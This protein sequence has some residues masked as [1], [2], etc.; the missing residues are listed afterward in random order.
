MIINGRTITQYVQRI[1]KWAYRQTCS[2]DHEMDLPSGSMI[3]GSV[4]ERTVR[5][6]VQ[7][8]VKWAYRQTVCSNGHEV[9]IPSNIMLKGS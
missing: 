1:M 2:N 9:N 6:Y 7:M 3:K 8:I 5:K 4:S